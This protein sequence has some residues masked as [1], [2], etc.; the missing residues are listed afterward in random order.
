MKQTLLSLSSELLVLTENIRKEKEDHKKKIEDMTKTKNEII[1]NLQ[2][3]RSS[4]D[5]EKI[6]IATKCLYLTGKYTAAGEQR[7]CLD[8][9]TKWIVTGVKTKYHDPI[10]GYFGCKDYSEWSSQRE[11]HSYGIGPRHGSTVFGIGLQKEYRT[12][13]SDLTEEQKEAIL[14]YIY[15]IEEI[16]KANT[17]AA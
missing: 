12:K 4:L 6:S 9:M 2:M 13:H 10:S 16:Q 5:L 14:Y 7:S 3:L 17:I 1:K 15:N 11:D 8:D